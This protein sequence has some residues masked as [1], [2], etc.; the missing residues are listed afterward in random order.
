MWWVCRVNVTV[1]IAGCG[2]ALNN[3]KQ[4]SI[5]A[6]KDNTFQQYIIT[7]CPLSNLC[8]VWFDGCFVCCVQRCIYEMYIFAVFWHAGI[9]KS[10]SNVQPTVQSSWPAVIERNGCKCIRFVVFDFSFRLVW[11]QLHKLHLS[12]SCQ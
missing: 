6:N 7:Y 8:P 5:F 2:A 12:N 4:L 9:Y 10:Y 3:L 1:V 11:S